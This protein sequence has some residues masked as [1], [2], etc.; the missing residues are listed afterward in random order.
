MAQLTPH[1]KILVKTA[2]AEELEKDA[3]D[4][5][6]IADMFGISRANV[7][8]IRNR[9]A[10]DKNKQNTQ[11]IH[12]TNPAL[13]DL[14]VDTLEETMPA[15]LVV[16]ANKL[17]DSA[18]SLQQLETEFHVTFKLILAK[19]VLFMNDEDLSLVDWQIITNTLAAA[20][21]DIYNTTG[22]TINVAKAD[23]IGGTQNLT[24]LKGR[25]GV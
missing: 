22:T 3:F 17:I 15:E 13:L 16:E 18:R 20:F 19:S 12:H 1:K 10:E 24:M 11:T 6:K 2:I 5:Q 21:K 23:S 4:A 7:Y 9:M 14:V 8:S 25:M